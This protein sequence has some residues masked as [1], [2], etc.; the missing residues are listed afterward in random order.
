MSVASKLSNR[1]EVLPTVP[2][3]SEPEPRRPG[4]AVSRPTPSARRLRGLFISLTYTLSGALV[5]AAFWTFLSWRTPE[6]PTPKA[7]LGTLTDLLSRAFEDGGPNG[8]GIGLQFATSMGR[9]FRGFTLAAMLAVP[10]GL[11]IGSSRRAWQAFNPIVQLLRPI[12]PLAWFPIGLVILDDAPKAAVLV[13]FITALWPIVINTA[14]GAHSVPADQ[15]N[16]ARVFKFSRA[17][18]LRRVLIPHTV[19]SIITGMRLSM[20]IAWMV[21]VA[22]EM[23]SGGSGIGFFVWDSYNGGNLKAVIAAVIIIGAIGWLLDA[24]FTAIG[25]RYAGEGQK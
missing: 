22:V 18:Y 9:T 24:M 17:T 19:P 3:A 11:L 1:T 16:V 21:I 8:K 5:F 20:G 14:A 7:A 12:S 4:R 15:R 25:R 2:S 23:L 10:I 13:I 6:L